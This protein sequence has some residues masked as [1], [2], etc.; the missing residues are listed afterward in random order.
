MRIEHA[1]SASG[2]K[3]EEE[4]AMREEALSDV[5]DVGPVAMRMVRQLRRQVLAGGLKA[6]AELPSV[7][8]LARV[9][10]SGVVSAH[11]ALQRIESEGWASRGGG[12]R[13]RI[14]Q[15]A[16][17][18][19]EAQLR[20]EPPTRIF[21]LSPS[22]VR[23]SSEMA[24]NTI[25][26][27]L[28][29]VFPG[30]SPHFLYVDLSVGFGSV[31]QLIRQNTELPC[32]VGYVLAGMPPAFKRLFA[33]YEL[34]CVVPGYVEPGVGLPCVCEDMVTVGRMAGELLCRS[35]RVVALCHQELIGA[36]VFLVEGVQE[37]ARTMGVRAPGAAEFYYH[38]L[39]DVAD[40]ARAIDLLLDQ[41]DGSLGILAVQPEFAMLALQAAAR[42]HIRIPEQVQVV[43]L[44]HHP[45]Y[46]FVYPAISSIGPYSLVELGR[47]CAE[48]LAES[49]GGRP[50]VAPR[51]I[52]RSTLI[53][54]ES[55][56]PRTTGVQR[57]AS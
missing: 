54:R 52:I 35:G 34:P 21:W 5:L 3:S 28:F 2:S 7:R 43:A 37:A 13:L 38:L 49:M 33:T 36:E 26:E 15:D 31:E 24:V 16:V 20:Q 47:R 42:R 55:T 12:R 29:R 48:M 44:H 40:Y 8:E 50:K 9:S 57:A 6:G 56:L 11:R 51:E 39:P 4:A 25:S 45:M 19:A 41:N 10:G 46:S 14:S 17:R 1:T 53:E 27:G 30:C 18:L 32:E 22:R 23:L